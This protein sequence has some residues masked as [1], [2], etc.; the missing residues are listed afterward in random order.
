MKRTLRVYTIMMQRVDL[1]LSVLHDDALTRFILLF[2]T[3]FIRVIN[4]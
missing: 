3:Y 4:S 2:Y 1:Q